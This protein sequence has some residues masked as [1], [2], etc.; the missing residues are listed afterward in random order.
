MK[1]ILDSISDH[2]KT[3][4]YF[5]LALG[6]HY[7]LPH[8]DHQRP[9]DSHHKEETEKATKEVS[10][11]PKDEKLEALQVLSTTEYSSITTPDER[12]SEVP[13]MDTKGHVG[14]FMSSLKA[15]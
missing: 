1:F 12:V 15:L 6:T 9:T 3:S 13:V 14:T 8:R 11:L 10:E 5:G 4:G 2:I 7:S